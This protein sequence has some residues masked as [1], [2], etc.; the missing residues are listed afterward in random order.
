MNENK[1]ALVIVGIGFLPAIAVGIW[2]G[3]KEG[4]AENAEKLR[5]IDEWETNSRSCIQN[6]RERMEKLAQ[7]PSVSAAEFYTEMMIE[8]RFL[9]IALNDRPL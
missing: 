9:N 8:N 5:K 1:K 6:Y 4:A 2:K 7:D 3:L